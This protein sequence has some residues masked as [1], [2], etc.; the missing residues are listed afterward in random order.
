MKRW[1]ELRQHT[2]VAVKLIA[3]EDDGQVEWHLPNE[4]EVKNM[5]KVMVR[6]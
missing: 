5:M 6:V 3:Q 4:T 1:P 2:S